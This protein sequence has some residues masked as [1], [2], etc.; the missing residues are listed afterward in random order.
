[1]FF[2]KFSADHYIGSYLH[3][4]SG[5]DEDSGVTVMEGDGLLLGE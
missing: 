1:V 5:A 2:L 4:P 3:P